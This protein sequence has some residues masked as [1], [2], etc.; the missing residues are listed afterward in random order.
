MDIQKRYDLIIP[1]PSANGND[2][3]SPLCDQL[4]RDGASMIRGD[5]ISAD[6]LFTFF[7]S[8]VILYCEDLSIEKRMA[9]HRME[10]YLKRGSGFFVP[11][12]VAEHLLKL[13]THQQLKVLLYLLAHEGETLSDADIALH[14]GVQPDHVEEAI[15]FWQQVNVLSSTQSQPSAVVKTNAASS[16]PKGETLPVQ[17]ISTVST[18]AEP[19]TA[20][21]GAMMTSGNFS[22]R[23]S[24]I[25]AR[26]KDDAALAALLSATEQYA[27]H[28]LRNTE[29]RSLFWMHDYLGMTPDSIL[30]LL[31]FCRQE[32]VFQIRYIEKIAVEWHDRGIMTHEQVQQ[33]IRRRTEARTFVGQIMKLFEMPR[34]PTERQEAYIHS[35]QA[36][37]DSIELIHLAYERTR[38]SC[39]DKLSFPYLDKILK[40]WRAE[41]LKTPAQ[42]KERE[43][44]FHQQKQSKKSAAAPKEPSAQDT[45][46]SYS[47]DDIKR[48]KNRL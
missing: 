23:P 34:T 4:C 39:D 12:A 48:L 17:P 7:A 41:G 38:E 46:H 37:G 3:L 24:E 15:A 42:V 31:A 28:P 11:S 20:P 27:G 8:C 18:T 9:V 44:V 47:M 43:A 45:G 6:N 32:N 1:Y 30:M 33:D 29:L 10:V 35:W 22:I 14:C 13:A 25:A 2:L 40:R 5:M 21:V 19:I 16:Q 36:A 26:V